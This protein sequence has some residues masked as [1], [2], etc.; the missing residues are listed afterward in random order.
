DARRPARLLLVRR[1]GLAR[2][3]GAGLDLVALAR[4]RAADKGA[5]PHHVARAGGAGA[6]AGLVGIAHVARAVA[7]DR[8]GIARRVLT[9]IARAVARVGRTGVA[10]IR[11]G[12][13]GRLL[14]VGR[15][16]RPGD[17]GAG[18]GV[19][20]LARRR[21]ADDRARRRRRRRA[22][23]AGAGAVLLGVADVARARVADRARVAR[24]V[25]AV[26][27]GPVALIERAG[28]AVVGARRAGRLLPVGR[29]MRARAGAELRRVALVHRRPTR[30]GRGFEGVGGADVA[31]PVA[32]RGHV[33]VAGRRAALRA[34]GLLG[35]LGAVRAR[36]VAQLGRVA[37][38]GRGP[39]LRPG[40]ASRVLAGV[41]GPVA[42]IER[43]GIRVL[44]ARRP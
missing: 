30:G 16:A 6:G 1:A 43:A 28:V 29:A 8:P 13:G 24:G 17:A 18:L 14:R 5:R 42:L 27:V 15:A 39:A 21:A 33:A 26:I 9:R 2:E 19:V 11:A 40:M 44:D 38:P 25:L 41:V 37:G 23:G 22:G 35:I 31:A 32:G 36:P 3:A 7:A 20:A 34:R 12:R 10:V 4:R